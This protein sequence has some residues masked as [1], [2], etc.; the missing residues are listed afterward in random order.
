MNRLGMIGSTHAVSEGPERPDGFSLVSASL[1]GEDNRR[2]VLQTLFDRGPTSRADLARL[3]G[4]NRT[5]I[6]GIVQPLLESGLLVEVMQKGR[7][8]VGKPPRPLWFS[9][10]ASPTCAITLMPDAI[11]TAMVSITGQIYAE[12]VTSID[13]INRNRE[14][15][16]RKLKASVRKSLKQA[17]GTSLGIGVAVGGM[18]DSAQGKIISMYLAPYLAGLDIR[19]E[20]EEAFGLPTVIDHH[21]RTILLGERWFGLGRGLRDFAVIYTGE[22]LGCALY[23]NGE[24]LRGPLSSGG[25]IG[26]TVVEIDGDICG[27]GRKGCW[28][29]VATLPWLRKRAKAL[30]LPNPAAIDIERL[31]ELAAKNEAAAALEAEYA[32]NLALGM[33]NLETLLM[34]GSFIVF[35]DVAR[36][37]DGFRGKITQALMEMSMRHP[38]SELKVVFGENEIGTTLRGAAGLVI[39]DLLHIKY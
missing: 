26:H 9:E 23:L 1:I 31:N 2:R 6:T 10:D 12:T 25:E 20:L 16:L 36:G 11:R 22:V 21:P 15:L 34:P 27:C 28:E 35:G 3:S 33:A 17:K 7:K 32:R 24:L 37:N 30:G 5:T 39:S 13:A 29:T 8:H 4:T 38:E 19:R 18:V 14:S